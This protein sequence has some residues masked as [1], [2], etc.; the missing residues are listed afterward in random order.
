MP[1]NL[2]YLSLCLYWNNQYIYKERTYCIFCQ[3]NKS[4]LVF[5]NP[6][7]YCFRGIYPNKFQISD[8]IVWLSNPLL[9]PTLHFLMPISEYRTTRSIK[10]SSN[11]Q[12]WSIN[13]WRLFIN[14]PNIHSQISLILWNVVS[15]YNLCNFFADK[16]LKMKLLLDI[17][18][19]IMH[20]LIKCSGLHILFSRSKHRSLCRVDLPLGQVGSLKHWWKISICL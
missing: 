10:V 20:N 18:H 5:L 11:P 13:K 12:K 8:S 17:M 16:C 15:F 1:W 19:R 3:M 6:R 14:A 7:R 4:I 2:N 9:P